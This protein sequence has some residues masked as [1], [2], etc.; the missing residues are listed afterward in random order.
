MTHLKCLRTGRAR[1]DWVFTI[2]ITYDAALSKY[3]AFCIAAGMRPATIRLRS[4]WL[5]RAA[6]SVDLLT[7]TCSDLISWLAVPAWQP[8]TRK[9]ARSALRSFYSW[10]VA[11]SIIGHD[12][13]ERLPKVRVPHGTPRPTP[14]PVLT[15]ALAQASERD[16]LIIALAAFAGLRRSEIAG[17]KWS[18][19][20]SSTLRVTGKGGHI[21]MVPLAHTLAIMLDTERR[22]RAA[23]RIGG[24]W[25]FRVDPAS[26]FILPSHK[27]GHLHP[28]T[29]GSILSAS[30]GMG[31]SG[32]TLRHRF[33]TKAFAVD[34]DLVTVQQLLGHRNPQTTIRYTQ[35]P[36]DAARAAVAG[37]VA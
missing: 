1:G 15:E 36:N 34:R 28:E 9:S 13:S 26:P 23:G 17:L 7:A 4:T 18:A 30:L 10:A 12:P 25:R 29:V 6:R 32:H 35:A 19:I 3:Q 11:E 37:A 33:A 27:G 8:E 24:G 5:R 2:V 22:H 20:E 16:R 21:R 14:T 31:W